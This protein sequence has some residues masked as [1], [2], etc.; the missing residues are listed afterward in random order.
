MLKVTNVIHAK[1]LNNAIQLIVLKFNNVILAFIGRRF[2][3]VSTKN[4][5]QFVLGKKGNCEDCKDLP[6][7]CTTNSNNLLIK[8]LLFTNLFI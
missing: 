7:K 1:D 5:M 4:S 3:N 2:V 6:L 8:L